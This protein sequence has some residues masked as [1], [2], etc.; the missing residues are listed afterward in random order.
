[1]ELKRFSPFKEQKIMAEF[2]KLKN[3]NAKFNS[4]S[5]REA[6]ERALSKWNDLHVNYPPA[7][8]R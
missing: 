2:T 4:Q 7:I 1:M 8:Q 3:K 5:L 6:C